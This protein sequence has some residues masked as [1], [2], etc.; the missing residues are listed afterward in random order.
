MA[1]LSARIRETVVNSMNFSF[2]QIFHLVDSAIVRA[3]I[4]KES[5]GFG[6]FV[7]NRI[8]EI[9][10]KTD[11]SEWF[12]VPSDVNPADLTTRVTSAGMITEE[13]TWQRGTRVPLHAH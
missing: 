13:S 4:Q 12:W 11:K 7:A 2:A 1:V 3:Q 10:S 6:T 9:Q 8:A 5:Y